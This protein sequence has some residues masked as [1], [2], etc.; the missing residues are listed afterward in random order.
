MNGDYGAAVVACVVAFAKLVVMAVVTHQACSSTM[1]NI[2][3]IA[4]ALLT[5][6]DPGLVVLLLLL[7]LKFLSLCILRYLHYLVPALL[8]Q[9]LDQKPHFLS[10]FLLGLSLFLQCLSLE[11]HFWSKLLL[12]LGLFLQFLNRK[13]HSFGFLV[14]GLGLLL[15]LVDL[16]I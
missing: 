15:Q 3:V 1:I 2:A 7:K 6:N 8:A 12:G 16:V 10:I 13:P 9:W 5:V 11:P 14:L 4:A